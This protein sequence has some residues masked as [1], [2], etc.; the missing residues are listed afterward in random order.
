MEERERAM[1]EAGSSN[2]LAHFKVVDRFFSASGRVDSGAWL[3]TTL[4]RFDSGGALSIFAEV[5]QS[6]DARS[7]NL[8]TL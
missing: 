6:V 2:L 5:A 3:Q 7:L 8:R 4:G 1:L